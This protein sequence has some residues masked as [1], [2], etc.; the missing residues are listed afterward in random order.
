[1]LVGALA[2]SAGTVTAPAGAADVEVD[3]TVTFSDL[4]PGETR[5]ESATITLDRDAVLEEIAWPETEGLLAESSLQAEVCVGSTCVDQGD[6]VPTAL[7][8][9]PVQVDVTV[10]A[11]QTIEPDA[12]G[13]ALG[14]LTFSADDA[15][16]AGGDGGRAPAADGRQLASTGA[17]VSAALLWGGAVLVGSGILLT[18]GAVRRRRDPGALS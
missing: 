2:L 17:Q 9:G 18:L 6:L 3:F 15:R 13:S 8:A 11:P 7:P 1:M 14:R 16:A 4:T 10:S 12:T 5:T